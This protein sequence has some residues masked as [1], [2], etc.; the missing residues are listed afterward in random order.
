MESEK[1]KIG[2]DVLTV[3]SNA[4]I[5][6]NAL[7][8]TGQLDRALYIKTNEIL[9]AAGGKWNRKAKAHLFDGDANEIIEQIIL[10]GEI[11]KPQDFGYF[12]TP[13]P[14]VTELIELAEIKP[15]M[16]VLEPSAGQGNIAKEIAKITDVDC[17]ELLPENV[18]KLLE[19]KLPGTVLMTDFLQLEPQ[20]IYDR[21]VM[22]PPFA[23]QDDI[24]HA[25]HALKFLNL[26]DC[27]FRLCRQAYRFG[28][29]SL[30]LIFE[31]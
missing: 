17:V 6:G 27:S 16:R 2:N 3:L 29:T 1:V 25:T 31:T 5:S 23:K 10:T 24:R 18:K 21:I 12:P 11:T 9:E 4:E 14:V 22:N 28:Q 13:E 7:K 26:T 20:P 30:P 19:L 8:L 15:G